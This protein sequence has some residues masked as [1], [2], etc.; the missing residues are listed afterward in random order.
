MCKFAYVKWAMDSGGL[1]LD[2]RLCVVCVLTCRVLLVCFCLQKTKPTLFPKNNIFQ[3]NLARN[4]LKS[5]KEW[6]K[7]RATWHMP[8]CC[9]PCSLS[10]SLLLSLSLA[11][12]PRS[13]ATCHRDGGDGGGQA[14]GGKPL[15]TPP[16]PRPRPVCFQSEQHCWRSHSPWNI[17][18]STGK[19]MIHSPRWGKS[20]PVYLSQLLEA[21][22][23]AV[24]FDFL[25]AMVTAR[26][27][28]L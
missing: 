27:P 23:V 20:W 3:M 17:S 7:T 1:S 24:G 9:F 19:H 22:I 12:S 16:N 10:C 26:Q 4:R 25:S 5:Q 13:L 18:H 28:S 21:G 11:C 8:L 2:E 15:E 14:G 6:R